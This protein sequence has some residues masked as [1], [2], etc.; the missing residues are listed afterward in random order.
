MQA[1]QHEAAAADVA[2]ARVR[3]RERVTDGHRRIHGVA[4]RAQH[5]DADLRRVVLRGD[6]HRVGGWGRGAAQ[7]RRSE[8]CYCFV[9]LPLPVMGLPFSVQLSVQ[10]HEVEVNVYAVLSWVGSGG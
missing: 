7:Q 2:A 1:D 6:D 4:A 9:Q 5:V 10:F 8:N 3:H